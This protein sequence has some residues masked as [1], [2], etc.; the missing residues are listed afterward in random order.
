MYN[1]KGYTYPLSLGVLA[2]FSF[3]L[4][5]MMEQYLMEKRFYQETE[6]I[7]LGEYYLQVAIIEIEDLYNKGDFPQSGQIAFSS[8]KVNF[9][10]RDLSQVL[11]E[12]T[13]SLTL[14]TNEQWTAIAHYDKEKQKI[15]KWYEKN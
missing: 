12:V 10:R 9:V 13:L 15:V 5:I 7:L 4:L 14:D 2:L 1:E 8:G 6:T 11:M 3:L